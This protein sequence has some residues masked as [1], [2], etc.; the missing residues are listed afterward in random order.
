MERRPS[1]AAQAMHGLALAALL[2]LGATAA[3]AQDATRAGTGEAE[4]PVTH[5]GS[6]DSYV[7]VTD[8]EPFTFDDDEFKAV[9]GMVAQVFAERRSDLLITFS[10][11]CAARPEDPKTEA[12]VRIRVL[13]DDEEV[14]GANDL[15][16]CSNKHFYVESHSFQWVF[17]VTGRRRREVT[18][19]AAYFPG[20]AGEGL[21]ADR[22]LRIDYDSAE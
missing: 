4:D 21:I 16:L 13:V 15:L 18:V 19:E 6:T 11:E 2:G 1:P 20:T 14:A 8:E 12:A 3:G 9:P 10:A 22:V 7:V 5:R 17:P